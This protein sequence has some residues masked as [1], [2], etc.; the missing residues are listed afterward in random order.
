MKKFLSALFSIGIIA[1]IVV[2]CYLNQSFVMRQVDKVKALYYV[3][4]GDE[5]YQV[6]NTRDSIKYY[7]KGLSLYP[8]HYGAWYNLGNIYVAYEDYSSALYAY[9]QAFK[10]NPKMMIARVNYGVISSEMLGDFDSALKQ[11]DEVIKTKR[12][13]IRIPYIYDNKYSYKKNKAIAYYNKGVT[14]RLKSLYTT[15]DWEL[16]RKYLAQ[17]IQAYKKS[18]EIDDKCYEAQYNL[19][20]AYHISGDYKRAGQCYCKAIS[21]S[22]MS[23]EPHYNLAVLLR[24]LG[25]FQESYDE[26]D[27]ATTLITANDENSS[28]QQYVS[29]V[30]NDITRSLYGRENYRKDLEIALAPDKQKIKTKTS[31]TKKKSKKKN[32]KDGKLGETITSQGISFV[33]GKISIDDDFDA[34]MTGTF[35]QCPA[36]VYF[37]AKKDEDEIP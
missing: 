17:A 13:L 25:H 15:D 18:I 21:L 24:K 2:G 34:V 4:K 30:L 32:K 6:M 28:I 8:K 22:P 29:I 1:L 36:S 26:I 27:K 31:N 19:A 33:N 10:Y 14:Y 9:S 37:E 11:Y 20:I 23:Y 3:H 16:Q 35:S 12:R 5:A 7:N